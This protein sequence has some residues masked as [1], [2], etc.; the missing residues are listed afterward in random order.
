MSRI[1]VDGTPDGWFDPETSTVHEEDLRW[2]DL[3]D[4]D[5]VDDADESAEGGY[6]ES[7]ATGTE[8][9]HERLY[10]TPDGR[11]VLMAWTDQKRTGTYSF[12]SDSGATA[13]LAINEPAAAAPR[14]GRPEVG[15][16]V[17][18]RLPA[19]LK[20]RVDLFASVN[21]I[22]RAEA[23]RRLVAGGLGTTDT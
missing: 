9:S 7:A 19:E 13:W 6:Y 11:W 5:D 12:L 17:H 15:E 1:D 20:E 21:G 14:R 22:S 23:V 18:L 16:P 2:I 4:E 8:H 3:T 10:H